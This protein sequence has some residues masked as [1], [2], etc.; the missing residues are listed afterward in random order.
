[1]L[2]SCKLFIIYL[3][4]ESNCMGHQ[5]CSL[6]SHGSY[7]LL[8]FDGACHPSYCRFVNYVTHVILFLLGFRRRRSY[9][10]K[11]QA[12]YYR[13]KKKTNRN[14][15][16]LSNGQNSSDNKCLPIVFI[17]GIGIGFAHYLLTILH[18]P[19]DVDVYL[20]EWPHVAMQLRSTVPTS[21][22]VRW[23][24][25]DIFKSTLNVIHLTNQVVC[26]IVRILDDDKQDS[27]C[28]VAH[29]L[30]KGI[31]SLCLANSLSYPTI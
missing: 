24:H 6:I 20:V 29:S 17:H 14:G 9:D 5:S 3:H 11:S 7:L 21:N 22:E 8:M 4:H 19:D 26:S 1:M 10:T 30:G 12:I 18:L 13:P 28:F 25:D 27:A 16:H 23:H 15:H 31:K 2:S